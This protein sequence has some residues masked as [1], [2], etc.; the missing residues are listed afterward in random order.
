MNPLIEL[1]LALILFVPWF[2][3]LGALF[4]IYPR[5]PRGPARRIYDVV[6]LLLAVVA[7]VYTQYWS[8][9]VAD[10]QY[11]RMWGQI[12]ATAIGYAVYLA[13]MTLAFFLRPRLLRKR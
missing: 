6:A 11:G 8:L 13:V 2:L 5:Q 1:N 3:I 10:P 7:F 9:G 4:W 12:L